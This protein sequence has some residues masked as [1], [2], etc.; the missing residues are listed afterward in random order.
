MNGAVE[1]LLR[2]GLDRLTADVRVPPGVTGRARA[3]LRR[4]KIAVRAALAG[5]AAAV[6]AAAVVAATVPGE[7]AAGPLQAR[8]T[9]YVVSRVAKALAAATANKVVQTRTT[10]SAPFP[11][12]IGWT[13]RG[14]L[15]GLQ[16]GYIAPAQVPGM[17]WA[18]GRVSW[19]A[20]TAMVG[21]KQIYVQ[22]DYRRHEWYRTGAMGF[23]PGGCA[24]RLDI[25]EFNGPSDW[26]PYLRQALSCG[27]FK[28]TGH[29][30]AGGIKAIKLTGSES[31][32]HFWGGP[33]GAVGRGPVRVDVTFYVNPATYV[34]VLAVWRNTS[35]WR[36]GK[37]MRGTVRQVIS[38]L[39]PTPANQAKVEVTIPASFRQV[40][41]AP[42][43]GPV[44]PYFTSG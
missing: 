23:V 6:T 43:G 13:Y 31:D 5:G 10:F 33:P 36:D 37:L 30:W 21:G 39:P 18:Q 41:G 34:P 17:P 2:E 44:F 25:V 22:V 40:H 20:G 27:M 8:T 42:F 1:E 7:G 12:V 19:G 28:V 29:A 14:A 38:L 32:P 15:R 9:A 4:K 16:A 24:T 35:H 26:A 11:P 3:H